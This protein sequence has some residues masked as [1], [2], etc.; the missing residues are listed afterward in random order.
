M[1]FIITNESKP[2]RTFFLIFYNFIAFFVYTYYFLI[3]RNTGIIDERCDTMHLL[4]KIQK[5]KKFCGKCGVNRPERSHH[6]SKCDRCIK[7]MDHHCFW[8]GTCINNDNLGHFVR[9]LFFST[10]GSLSLFGTLTC[11][12]LREM[13]M[14]YFSTYLLYMIAE[15]MTALFSLIVGVITLLFLIVNVKNVLRNVTYIESV[16]CKNMKRLGNDLK[17]NP[18][19]MGAYC[20]FKDVMGKA[21][22]LFLFGE[23]GDGL[24]F[25]KTYRIEN[26]PRTDKKS[27]NKG[28]VNNR[29]IDINDV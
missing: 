19:D 21:K 24:T 10:L 14:D 3:I 13:K 15:V 7:K 12:I 28:H 29:I 27:S 2:I 11:K 18:Y 23:N 1:I 5:F 6:C 4:T 9:F 25:K 22:F 16:T 26:W 17:K 8:L 20:N